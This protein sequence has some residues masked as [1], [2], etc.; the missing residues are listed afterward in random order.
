MSDRDSSSKYA[1]DRQL[2]GCTYLFPGEESSDESEVE[3]AG[4]TVRRS[5]FSDEEEG[6]EVKGAAVY[7][8]HGLMNIIG[9]RFVGRCG[10][11]RS[12]ASQSQKSS[13]I[14]TEE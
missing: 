6:S 11:F 4:S 2:T 8:P 12:R 7:R 3:L 13:G 9:L 14:E 1:G 10:R 5:R